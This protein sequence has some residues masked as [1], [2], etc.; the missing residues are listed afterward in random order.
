[1]RGLGKFFKTFRRRSAWREPVKEA[2]D[3]IG[4]TLCDHLVIGR[5]GHTSFRA[6]GLL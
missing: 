3:K 5:K 1:M 2:F 6:K 4:I